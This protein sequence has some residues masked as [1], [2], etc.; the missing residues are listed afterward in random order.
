MDPHRRRRGTAAARRA[1]RGRPRRA[2]RGRSRM[3]GAPADPVGDPGPAA[4]TTAPSS[5][6]GPR[7]TAARVAQMGGLDDAQ[8][9]DWL[10][11]LRAG[12]SCVARCRRGAGRLHQ[13]S[14]RSRSVCSPPSP[15]REC[16]SRACRRCPAWKVTQ[17]HVPH[18]RPAP[19]RAMRWG[20]RWRGLASVLWPIQARSSR[21][22]SRI[23]NP[24][25][26]RFARWPTR[27]FVR[28][29]SGRGT[30]ARRGP[31][32]SRSAPPSTRRRWWRQRSTSLRSRMRRCRWP[33]PR[34]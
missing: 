9:P 32:T 33:A 7:I 23:S 31:T 25:G 29:C 22:P 3:P 6:A 28:C 5:R 15:P 18:G 20:K 16:A 26:R 12:S 21:S 14:L 24:G 4:M 1:R 19:R 34:H 13:S 30:K 2:R 17:L 8:L 10:A 27:F 11:S